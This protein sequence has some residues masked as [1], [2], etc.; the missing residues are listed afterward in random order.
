MSERVVI[1]LEPRADRAVIEAALR[2]AGAMS[3]D[4]FESLP[5]TLLATVEEADADRFVGR[6]Q[7]LAGV[8][9]AERDRLRYSS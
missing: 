5:D 2:A 6:A 1:S 3:V 9:H 7:Q 8:R 4:A